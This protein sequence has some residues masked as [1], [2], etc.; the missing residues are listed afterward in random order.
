MN[1]IYTERLRNALLLINKPEGYTSFDIVARLKKMLATKKI[2]H[3]GTLDKAASGLLVICTGL[4][5]KLTRY[6]L[7]SDKEYMGRVQLGVVTDTCD[8]EG[9]VIEKKSIAHVT[10]K[11]IHAVLKACSGPIMQTPPLYSALK[12]D[13]KRASDRVRRGERIELD[14]REVDIKAIACSNINLAEGSFDLYVHCS[15]GTYI[16][17]LARDIGEA[18][19]TGAYLAR[20]TR[21]VSGS[22]SI[23]DSVTLAE[24][25]DIIQG[26]PT[27]KHFYYTMV[28]AV[29]W[30]NKMII[31]DNAVSRVGNGAFFPR[32][33]IVALEDKGSNY[34]AIADKKENLIAIADIDID[35]WQIKYLNVFNS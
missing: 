29:A 17:S 12:V 10:E 16:R 3:S 24:L 2:G 25:E 33:N 23:V 5:T 34:Y 27:T 19:G 22:Y 15:K 8:R 32:S 13:G 1:N 14:A 26:G 4:A 30:M 11:K 21:L 35:N 20:L 7:E 31:A 18:L 9:E 28:Q 6:F